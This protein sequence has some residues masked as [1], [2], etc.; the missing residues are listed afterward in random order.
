MDKRNRHDSGSRGQNDPIPGLEDGRESQ[1]QECE[2]LLGAGKSKEMDSP[3]G[4]LDRMWPCQYV[5]FS[6]L[7]L[8]SD[9]QLLEL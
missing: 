6:P 4:L 7:D 8:F 2:E 3:L 9:F 5:D 1:A